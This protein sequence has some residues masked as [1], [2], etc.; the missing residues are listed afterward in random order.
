MAPKS[1]TRRGKTSKAAS[2]AKWIESLKREASDTADASEHHSSDA[3]CADWNEEGA[4]KSKTRSGK[5]STAASSASDTAHPW[6]ARCASWN[7]EG[8]P[9][10]KHDLSD[11][12]KSK[13]SGI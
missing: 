2:T 6:A 13:L 11:P 10:S 12:L 5:R 9:L 8:P 4:D 7:D 3:G 1:K